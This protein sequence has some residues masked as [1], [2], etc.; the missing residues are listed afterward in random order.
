MAAKWLERFAYRNSARVVALS[1]V[2]KEGVISTGYPEE[3]VTVIP[4][5][6]DL[7]LFDV[8]PA[9]GREMRARY[10][11]LQDR[12]LFVYAGTIGLVN[13]L[14]Y[15]AR[16]AAATWPKDPEI[17]FLIIG[18]GREEEKV[19]Q[20]AEELGVYQKNFFM[21]GRVSKEE[22]PAWLSAADMAS[23]ICI[24]VKEVWLDSANKFFDALAAGRPVAINYGGWMADFL[25]ENDIG[26]VL[27]NYD[28]ETSANQI[29]EKLNDKAW[30]ERAT[31]DAQEL[32]R[33]HFDR[34]DL[35]R[36]LEQTLQA[37]LTQKT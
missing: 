19:R 24:D 7:E 33:Q 8:D 30:L 31:R 21:L 23:S 10:P 36:Q 13:G 6:S 26:L 20:T 18:S 2:M 17:R 22:I 12:P 28:L 32:A 35:A 3:K 37:S 11:W 14:E 16:L 34:N 29:V 15:L 9:R 5:S 27:S 25:L 1:P 4:N